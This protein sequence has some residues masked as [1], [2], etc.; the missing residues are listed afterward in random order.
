[1]FKNF[2]WTILKVYCDWFILNT[3]L[4]NKAKKKTKFLKKNICHSYLN[5]PQFWNV[6]KPRKP[7]LLKIRILK[8]FT[9][10]LLPKFISLPI[11]HYPQYSIKF[12][13]G[14]TW[15]TSTSSPIQFR[16]FS[17]FFFFS[18]DLKPINQ[19]KEHQNCEET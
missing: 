1:M 5:S 9:L 16:R 17:C 12:H 3:F 7:K 10:Q 6:S 14:S 4:R 2:K 15:E 18:L 13:L 8:S 19:Q 11:V